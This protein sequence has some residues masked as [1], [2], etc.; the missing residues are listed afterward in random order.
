MGMPEFCLGQE[1]VFDVKR[2][3]C[4]KDE[5]KCSADQLEMISKIMMPGRFSFVLFSYEIFMD[6]DDYENPVKT[7][8]KIIQARDAKIGPGIPL[9]T[10][11]F[12]VPLNVNSAVVSDNPLQSPF[13]EEI[14]GDWLYLTVEGFSVDKTDDNEEF[15]AKGSLRLS[16]IMYIR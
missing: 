3:D 8:T 6:F 14:T 12:K 5:S 9:D 10:L 13:K 2:S 7:R 15:F 4:L 1:V 11:N 16:D